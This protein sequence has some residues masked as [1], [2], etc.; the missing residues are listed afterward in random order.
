VQ[1]SDEQ[2]AAEGESPDNEDFKNVDMVDN[3]VQRTKQLTEEE[4]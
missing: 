2:Q 4:L 1:Q 3:P